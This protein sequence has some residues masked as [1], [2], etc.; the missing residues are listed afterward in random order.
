MRAAEAGSGRGSCRPPTAAVEHATRPHARRGVFTCSCWQRCSI[1]SRPLHYVTSRHGH[2]AVDDI[3]ERC[4]DCKLQ[5]P[6][7]LLVG[8][9]AVGNRYIVFFAVRSAS[10]TMQRSHPRRIS[11][12]DRGVMQQQQFCAS[13]LAFPSCAV[14]RGPAADAMLMSSVWVLPRLQ[15]RL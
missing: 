9:A 1:T 15:E 14:K 4:S 11:G 2:V 12:V 3:F 10:R 6:V 13:C 5:L 8:D 7:L